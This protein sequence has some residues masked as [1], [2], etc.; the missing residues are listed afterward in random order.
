[1]AAPPKVTLLADA[2]REVVT[3]EA[4]ALVAVLTRTYAHARELLLAERVARLTRLQDGGTLDLDPATAAIRDGDWTV[5]PAPAHLADRRCEITGPADRKMMVSALNSGARVFLCDLEDA[6]SPTWENIVEGHRNIVDAADGVLEF[7]RGNG[8]V[9][10]VG[11]NPATIVVRPR[12][13]HLDEPRVLVDGKPCPAGLFDIAMLATGAGKAFAAA[14]KP[15]ALYLPKIEAYPEAQWWDALIGDVERRTGLAPRSIRVTVLIETISAALQMDEILFALRERITGLNAGRWDYLFS[16]VKQLGRDPAHLLPDRGALTMTV[17]FMAAYAERL[18]AI[19]H[20]RGAHAIGGMAPFVP[21]RDDPEGTARAIE[22]TRADKQVEAGLGY[23]GT[24]VAHPALVPVA[25]EVFDAAFGTATDQLL[26]KAPVSE[27]VSV[28]LD[29]AVP[30][31]QVTA[32]GVRANVA[33][34]LGY[35][36]AW[37]AGRGAVAIDGRMEDMATAEI[38]RCQLWQWIAQG[39]SDEHGEKVTAARVEALLAAEVTL[40]AVVPGRYAEAAELIRSTALGSDLPQFLTLSA[41]EK[42]A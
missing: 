13:L 19:C 30:G 7:D 18:V 22:Q 8:V 17:P 42:L 11:P 3:P 37:L 31:A 2:P 34:A 12:G 40:H 29:T 5:P 24:W 23:D 9:D 6:L 21:Q 16:I 39:V 32:V 10:A 38:A 35:L 36:A 41:L 14:G 27:D 25:T 20:R 1:M 15:L 33:V 28:L 26:V 4:L